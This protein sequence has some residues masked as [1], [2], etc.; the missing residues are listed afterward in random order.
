[1]LQG[2]G[3]R[4]GLDEDVHNLDLDEDMR[5]RMHAPMQ[6]TQESWV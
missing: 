2:L 3:Q 5:C 1:M 6:E 4:L